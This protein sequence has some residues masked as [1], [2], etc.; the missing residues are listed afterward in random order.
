MRRYGIP[1]APVMIGVVLGPLAETSLRN[2][3]M[4][5]GGHVT[6][7]FSSAISLT[8]YGILLIVIL[9]T[10]WRRIRAKVSKDV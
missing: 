5:S 2:A 4:S 1:L 9:Y 8:L 10:I 7:L 6:D 3:M